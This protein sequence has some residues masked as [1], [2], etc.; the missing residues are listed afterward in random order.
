M[1]LPR[2]P[3]WCL[4]CRSQIADTLANS[5]NITYLP[6]Q[7]KGGSNVLLGLPAR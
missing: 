3:R 4:L 1:S 2:F 5:P 6:S 7:A